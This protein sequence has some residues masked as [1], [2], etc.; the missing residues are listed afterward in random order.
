L[1]ERALLNARRTVSPP[2]ILPKIIAAEVPET[3]EPSTAAKY[4][5]FKR[6]QEKIDW[7]LSVARTPADAH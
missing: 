6:L 5:N 1:S 4:G 7:S 3:H 2:V